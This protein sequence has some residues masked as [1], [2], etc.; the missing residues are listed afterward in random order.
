MTFPSNFTI[1]I[2]YIC[3]IERKEDF[4]SKADY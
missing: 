1:D 3:Q 4:R 2:Q